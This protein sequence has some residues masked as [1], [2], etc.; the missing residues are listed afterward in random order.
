[1]KN[2]KTF[3]TGCRLH[4]LRLHKHQRTEAKGCDAAATTE[5][6]VPHSSFFFFFPG[7]WKDTSMICR[8]LIHFGKLAN[9]TIA[10]P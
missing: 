6:F 5:V 1:M 4:W 8:P 2:I 10:Y 9:A 7:I 3:F